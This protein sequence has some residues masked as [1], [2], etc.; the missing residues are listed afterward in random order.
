MENAR[1]FKSERE[2]IASGFFLKFAIM[3]YYFCVILHKSNVLFPVKNLILCS[4]LGKL[5]R[6]LELSINDLRCG[7][8]T[9]AL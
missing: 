9:S 2:R 6:L 7:V 3:L 1:R 8:N 4:K 5:L